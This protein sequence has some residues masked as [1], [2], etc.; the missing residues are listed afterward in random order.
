MSAKIITE[1]V[2][3][4]TESDFK[5][6]LKKIVSSAVVSSS[7]DDIP[8]CPNFKE[9][10]I[11]NIPKAAKIWDDKG[12]TPI[13]ELTLDELVRLEFREEIVDAHDLPS[14][15]WS[16][17]NDEIIKIGREFG[18]TLT[19]DDYCEFVAKVTDDNYKTEMNKRTTTQKLIK[20]HYDRI[21]ESARLTCREESEKIAQ[22]YIIAF[23]LLSKG[24]LKIRP[25]QLLQLE[26]RMIRMI[27]VTKISLVMDKRMAKEYMEQ[28]DAADRNTPKGMGTILI[29]RPD[30]VSPEVVGK[31]VNS[32][33]AKN[34]EKFE[35]KL[36]EWRP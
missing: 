19:K 27:A 21:I 5:K 23:V 18:I 34:Q 22:M 24:M 13:K 8:D 36:S 10:L 17:R 25:D 33:M 1:Y 2:E 20:A 11:A 7:G 4:M 29:H 28:H 9:R 32:F 35:A 12:M 6:I 15:F 14:T 3:S 16:S 31:A 30:D 26:Q